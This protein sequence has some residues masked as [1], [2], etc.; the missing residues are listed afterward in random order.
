MLNSSVRDQRVNE[1]HV[2]RLGKYLRNFVISS[3]YAEH[4]VQEIG[5]VIE[6]VLW[7]DKGLTDI[8]LVGSSSNRRQLAHES[9]N[10]KIDR[11]LITMAEVI[12]EVESAQTMQERIAIG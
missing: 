9:P 10:R 6:V 1:E 3:W 2:E 5:A 12:V 11:T 4:H 7:V 8:F